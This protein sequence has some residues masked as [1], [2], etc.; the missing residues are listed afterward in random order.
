MQKKTGSFHCLPYL[1]PNHE[2]YLATDLIKI[3]AVKCECKERQPN[4]RHVN[5]KTEVVKG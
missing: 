1:D 5:V 3:T 4:H 2:L